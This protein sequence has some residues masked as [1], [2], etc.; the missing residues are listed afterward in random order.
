[1]IGAILLAVAT[2]RVEYASRYHLDS[3]REER[4][5]TTRVLGI[6]VWSREGRL[7]DPYAGLYRKITGR[8]PDPHRWKQMRADCV[9][10]LW[11]TIF[12]CGGLGHEI[13]QRQEMLG[14]VYQRYADTGSQ[15]EA[16]AQIRRI[17]ELLP[18]LHGAPEIL[19]FESIEVMRKEL[20]L[21]R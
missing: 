13:Q 20:G 12:R 7:E 1:V 19:D 5:V 15:S 4:H 6:P 11:M 18:C 2:Y 3:L 14:A 17:D 8:P 21:Q 9:S 10:S 16:A